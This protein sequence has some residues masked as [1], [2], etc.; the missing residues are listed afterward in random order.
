MIIV[1][2]YGRGLKEEEARRE[3]DFAVAK[4]ERRIL[5]LIM[6]NLED[7]LDADLMSK[8]TARTLGSENDEENDV[9]WNSC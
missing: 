6:C 4:Y 5:N 3:Y 1:S 7:F 2:S 8:L 9:C